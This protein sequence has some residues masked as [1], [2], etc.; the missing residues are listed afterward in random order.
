MSTMTVKVRIGL[1]LG[2]RVALPADELGDL[3]AT[4]EDTGFDS[5]WFSDQVSGSAPDP[6]VAMAVTAARTRRLKFGM[7]VMVL[8]GR[9]P[10]LLAK[11]LATLD[12]V[13]RGR[14][15]PAFGLGA[16]DP[17]EQSAFAQ[18]RATR[19]SVFDEALEVM[20]RCWT[21]DVVDH[22]GRHFTFEGVRVSPKPV[23]DPPEV[24]LGGRA[25]SELRRVGRLADGWLPSFVTPADAESGWMRVNEVAAEHGRAIDPGH[26]GVL[27]PWTAGE[28]PAALLAALAA[29]RPDVEDPRAI[30]PSGIAA[31]RDVV[32]AHVAVGA[33]KFVVLPMDDPDS[34]PRWR[35]VLD[36]LAAGVLDLQN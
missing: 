10:V 6:V 23:Q 36:E 4:V 18:D 33:S 27:I 32:S 7:S 29:R 5:L 24:W 28:P 9:N 25:E 2:V 3:A 16:V 31:L 26:F 1:G 17:A 12:R 8:P 22:H 15:L 21:E 35:G 13:S 19:G 34:L 11:Q 30:V 20:R 14:F